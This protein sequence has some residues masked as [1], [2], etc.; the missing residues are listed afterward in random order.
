MDLQYPYNTNLP[1]LAGYEFISPEFLKNYSF[2]QMSLR[3]PPSVLLE[4]SRRHRR[5]HP[6]ETWH[7]SREHHM[8]E[9]YDQEIKQQQAMHHHQTKKLDQSMAGLHISEQKNI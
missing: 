6:H 9:K 3:V 7:E 8:P 4:M 2:E 5:Q 1:S